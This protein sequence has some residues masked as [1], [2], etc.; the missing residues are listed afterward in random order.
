M[1]AR[2]RWLVGLALAAVASGCGSRVSDEPQTEPVDAT[3]LDDGTPV[4]SGLEADTSACPIDTTSCAGRCVDTDHDPYHCGACDRACSEG[5]V[6]HDGTCRVAC[7]PEL[8]A[9]A[10]SCHDVRW[11]PAHCGACD[12]A[13]PSGQV[14]SEGTCGPSCAAGASRCGDVCADVRHDPANCGACGVA[15]AKGGSCVEGA[16]ACPAGAPDVCDGRCVDTRTDVAHCGACGTLCVNVRCATAKIPDGTVPG[17]PLVTSTGCV[18]AL[19]VAVGPSHACARVKIGSIEDVWCWGDNKYGQ[20]GRDFVAADVVPAPVERK[21]GPWAIGAAS[22]LD[23][24]AGSVFVRIGTTAWTWG[25]I[26]TFYP[27]SPLAKR[28]APWAEAKDSGVGSIGV[29]LYHVCWTPAPHGEVRCVGSDQYGELGQG[30]PPSGAPLVKPPADWPTTTTFRARK[31]SSVHRTTCALGDDGTE[32][33]K[34]Y[35]WGKKLTT[36]ESVSVPT[37]ASDREAS[38]VVVGASHACLRD[39]TSGV[40]ACWGKNDAGQSGLDRVTYGDTIAVPTDTTWTQPSL[41]AGVDFNCGLNAG[42]VFCWGTN[43]NGELG[44]GTEVAWSAAPREVFGITGAVSVSTTDRGACAVKDDGTIW[45][46]GRQD[47]GRFGKVANGIH[48]KPVRVEF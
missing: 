9:C 43:A 30:S 34:V 8:M 23:V 28:A 39:K 11:D 37:K 7:P 5:E 18:K 2:R 48:R 29:G 17:A 16:C 36:N 32:S 15:C 47:K 27:E 45:C 19:E 38:D 46:W 40:W 25:R 42:K 33:R 13:C 3:P 4:D 12:T 31:L 21:D 14:C 6:C 24:G 44:D 26:V 20:L 35:C 10:G 41:S 22:T 1:S